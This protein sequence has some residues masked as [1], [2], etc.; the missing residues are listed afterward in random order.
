MA[1]TPPVTV[2]EFKAEFSREFVYGVG[3]D[4]VRDADLNR[5]FVDALSVYNPCLWDS[6]SAKPAFMY[7][8]AHFLVLN[9]QT[10]GGVGC[11]PTNIGLLNVADGVITSKTAGPLTVS[12]TEPPEFVK[13]SMSLL[14]FWKTTFG[15]M[16]VQ[17]LGP[18]LIGN[19]VTVLGEVDP[20][21]QPDTGIQH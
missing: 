16:Y 20:Q 9:I 8:A 11:G 10:A 6:N 5:A 19:V 7:A 17:M 4:S 12:Y 2:T 13:R 15:Q 21:V 3:L 18:R 14:P 1:L